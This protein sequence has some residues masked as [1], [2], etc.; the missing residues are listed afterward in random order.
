MA[1]ILFISFWLLISVSVPMKAQKATITISPEFNLPKRKAFLG[2]LHSN[3][4]GHYVHFA[5]FERKGEASV[6]LEKFD[7][8]FKLVFS[9]EFQSSRDNTS[10]AGVKYL[11]GG[12]IWLIS[13][14][15][16]K[17][18][19]EKYYL[20]P[21]SLDGQMGKLN[22][23]A[24]FKF[25]H[26]KDAPAINWQLSSD[27]TKVLFTARS[28]TRNEDDLIEFYISVID[29]KFE[30]V[31]DNPFQLD[32]TQEQVKVQEWAMTAEGDVFM[33]AKVY[34]G[35]GAKESRKEKKERIANYKM[36]V[37]QFS[38]GKT[39]PIEH[40]LNLDQDYIKGS[41]I[42]INKSDEL[43]CVGFFSN[44]RKGSTTGVFYMRLSPKDGNV[45]AVNK[46]N[47]SEKELTILGDDNTSKDKTGEEGID[48]NFKFKDILFRDNG[49]TL[50][51]AEENYLVVTHN[52]NTKGG[53]TTT[54]TYYSKDIIVLDINPEGKISRTTLIPKRQRFHTDYFEYF[55]TLVNKDDVYFFYNDDIDNIKKPISS[56]PKYISS[57][58]DCVATMTHLDTE[59]KLTRK[60]IL[61]KEDSKALFIPLDSKQF[62]DNELFFVCKKFKLLG[63]SDFRMGVVTVQ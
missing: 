62:S 61:D 49:S 3:K 63:P 35:E 42:A 38:K 16:E 9:K 51:T 52:N 7:P 4:S 47:F 17:K 37:Y 58:K 41:T 18:D 20:A 8:K 21:I 30:T 48:S 2:H 29:E 46:H 10:S 55:T 32:K 54:Y 26:R 60:Q 39:V 11:K 59:G 12:F 27:S 1:R 44:T 45:I 23:V 6:I 40:V 14:R 43:A 31:W 25:K 57:F 13:E 19:I 28:D 50:V 15:D 33:L 5:E 36:V 34:E 53:S 22:P 56:K 24:S